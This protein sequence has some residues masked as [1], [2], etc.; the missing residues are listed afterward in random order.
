METKFGTIWRWLDLN[1]P[2]QA[3]C[4]LASW[5][6]D[7]LEELINLEDGKIYSPASMD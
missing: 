7:C 4:M 2:A 5:Y 1:D 6:S 3:A